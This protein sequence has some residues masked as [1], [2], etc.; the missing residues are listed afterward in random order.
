MKSLDLNGEERERGIEVVGECVGAGRAGRRRQQVAAAHQS[1]PSANHSKQKQSKAQSASQKP[2][3]HR[4]RPNSATPNSS[5]VSSLPSLPTCQSPSPAAYLLGTTFCRVPQNKK[6]IKSNKIGL[7]L[8][9]QSLV[10][11]NGQYPEED[12][13]P[14]RGEWGPR[15]HVAEAHLEGKHLIKFRL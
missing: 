12:L 4:V 9:L 15:G 14:A 13:G 1:T 10:V 8:S 3:I 7:S 11:C 6:I 2:R 5:H